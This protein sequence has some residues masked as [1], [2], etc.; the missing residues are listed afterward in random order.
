MSKKYKIKYLPLF[1]SD[2]SEIFSY[3]CFN[4]KNLSAAK[5]IVARIENAILKRAENPKGYKKY[6]SAKDRENDY[7]RI[8]VRNFSVFY[9][10]IA[11][12]MEVRRAIYSKRDI[13][14]L[15]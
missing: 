7:Y 10:V 12:V 14:K 5:K 8:N 2:L 4:L 15:V 1:D 9:V 13:E 3:I 6:R 11:D